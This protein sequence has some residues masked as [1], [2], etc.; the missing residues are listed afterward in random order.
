MAHA[1]AFL[2]PVFRVLAAACLSALAAGAWAAG[3][4]YRDPSL[5]VDVRV[6]DLLGRMTLEEKVAQLQDF[7]SDEDRDFDGRGNL[8]DGPRVQALRLGAG[9]GDIEGKRFEDD[10]RMRILE[11]NSMQRYALERSRLGIPLTQFSEAVHGY[12][13]PGATSFPAA[14]ALAGTWDPGLVERVFAAAAQEAGARGVRQVLAPVLDLARDPRWGRFEECYGEDPYLVARIGL[15]AIAGLQGPGPSIGPE[16]VAVTL[17]HFAGHGQAEGGRN[18][19]PVA[20]AE[21]DF[22]TNHLYPFEVAVRQGHAHSVMASYNEWDGIPNHANPWLLT[23]VLRGEWGFD[24]YVM[25]DDEGIDRVFSEHHAAAGFDAAGVL[26]INAG[27]DYDLGGAGLCY[28]NL[29]AAVRGGR[30]PVGAVDRAAAGVL[31]IKFLTGLFERPYTDPDLY[32][33]VT[34][35]RAH[36]ELA[37]R[38][39]QE[40]VVLLKN[41]GGLLPLA[42]ARIRSLAVIGPNAAEVHLGGYSSVP[43]RGTSIL[44]G[45]RDEAGGAFEVL[46]SEGCR[47]TANHASGWLANENPILNSEA[48]DARLTAEAVKAAER[49]DAVVL[50]LGENELLRREAWSEDHLG[51]RDS[52]ELVGRQQ[53]LADAVVATGKPVVVLLVNGGP[54]AVGRLQEKVPA[55]LECWYLGEE[56]G[57][58]VADILFGRAGPG[59]RLTVT[60]PRSVGQLP[61]YYDHQ[62][63]RMRS[64]VL[65]DSTP[66][67]PFGFGLT[68]SRFS[69]SGLAVTPSVIEPGGTAAVTVDV[70]NTGGVQA[71]EV[72]Q[73]YLHAVASL[74]VRPV[75]ELK[76]FARITLRPGERRAVSFLLTPEKLESYDTAMKRR[77]QPG[78]FE[79]LVGGSS[80]DVSR[81]T[82]RV[83][84]R[85]PGT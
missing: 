65:A 12:M 16:H 44:Q 74:P 77:V 46:Y 7:E 37:R 62:P 19:A 39:A 48:D 23:G 11:F 78:D 40:A 35:T 1:A 60:F 15:A 10:P 22:R 17:K 68:Y 32:P 55:I 63:S 9:E 51:D 36:L 47:L 27:L 5:P 84:G 14:I 59:G 66:L 24:G 28:A 26:C 53:A 57:H 64:Y 85:A 4:N 76:D 42:A 49:S 70:A 58:A 83:A 72:V 67:Y 25:S 52:L 79:I 50:V 33:G 41:E 8:I 80:A 69:Y 6:G 75:E 29:A 2:A 43:M 13:A 18:T 38:A 82:L 81:V 31:R 21:R 3:P 30:V 73:L 20:L 56:A 71:D 34:R 54:L 45:I 61:A